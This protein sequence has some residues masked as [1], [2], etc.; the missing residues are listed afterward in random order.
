MFLQSRIRWGTCSKCPS[1]FCN[2][3]L[4]GVHVASVKVYRIIHETEQ[5]EGNDSD[6]GPFE[7]D[8]E[9]EDQEQ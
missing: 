2:Q 5:S 3:G 8:N 1:C 6:D 4:G 7:N 9:P